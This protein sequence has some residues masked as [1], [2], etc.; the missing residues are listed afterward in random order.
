M[1]NNPLLANNK[2]ETLTTNHKTVHFKDAA[3]LNQLYHP[4][5]YKE[6]AM[7][8][9]RYTILALVI[10]AFLSMIA[11]AQEEGD[12]RSVETGDWSDPSIWETFN[13]TV[14]EAAAAAPTGTETITILGEDSVFVDAVNSVEGYVKVE[15][16]GILTAEEGTLTFADGSTYEHAR[17]GG[18][19]PT[20]TWEEGSTFLITGSVGSAPDN[21]N[22]SY[23]NITFDTDSLV[24]NL[25][26]NL[27]EVTIGGDVRV[28]STGIARWYLTSATAGDTSTVT[29]LGDVIVE[30][31]QF[32]VQGTGNALTVFTVHHY[33]DINVTGGNFSISRGSQGSGSGSTHWYLY[34]GDFTMS[35]ATTQ[36]SNSIGARFVFASADTQAIGFTNVSFAGGRFNFDVS[37]STA[38]EIAQDLSVNG[39]LVNYGMIIPTA[40]LTIANGGIYEHAQNGGTIPAI[41]WAEGS[42]ALF[43]GITTD[44][45]ADRGQGYH[46]LTLNTPDLTSNR[47]LSLDGNTIGGNITV[48]STGTARWQMVGGSSGTVTIMGD[49]I[50]EDGQFA[51]QGTGSATDVE[52]LHH[53]NIIVTGGNFAV[54]RGSQ[55]GVG[56]TR[57][58]LLE[59]DFS[60]SNATTQ[61]SNPAGATFV[62]AKEGIQHLML[63]SVTYAGGGLPIEVAEGSTLDMGSSIIEGNAAFIVNTGGTFVTAHPDGVEGNLQTTGEITLSKEASFMFNGTEAQVTSTLMPDTVCTLIIDNEAGVTLSQETTINCVLRLVSGVFDNTIPFTFGPSGSISYEGGSLLI[64]D[65]PEK[66]SLWGFIGG[67]VAGWQITHGAPGNV[68]LSG[69]T[70]LG[71]GWS[72]IRGEFDPL[73]PGEGE[74]I[75]ISGQINTEGQGLNQ[76]NAIRYGIFRH[77]STGTLEHAGTDSARWSGPE[78]YAYG[79]LLLTMSGTNERANWLDHGTA[80]DFGVIYGGSWISTNSAGSKSLGQRDQ[81]LFRAEAP[82]GLYDFA[83][84][85]HTQEDGNNQL[86]YLLIHED[87][88]YWW[89][90]IAIDTTGV[91]T[92][93]Y[94]GVCF[95]L[96]ADSDDMTAVH[97]IDISVNVGD[98]IMVPDPP[99][100]TPPHDIGRIIN[101]N[102]NFELSVPGVTTDEP[103]W[104]FNYN[105]GGANAVF[106][107][108]DDTAQT[109]DRS[110]MIDFGTWNGASDVWHV[111]AVNEP[112]YPAEGDSIRAT[113][114]LKADEDGR[115]ARIYLGL[116]E[117]GGWQRV[118]NWGMEVV[119][120]LTTEWQ[121]FAFPDYMVIPRDVTHASQSMRF[122]IEF[123][124]QVNDGGMFWIDNAIVRKV[125]QSQVSVEDDPTIPLRF[126]LE[127]NYPNPFNP[128]TQIQFSITE[129]SDVLLEVFDILGRR[130]TTLVNENLNIGHHTVTWDATDQS[131]RSISSGLYIY[132]L[133]AGTKV[134]TKRMMFLK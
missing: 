99:L 63:D 66:V 77:D 13:G 29:I 101:E 56:T 130:V 89:A 62:F 104:S 4:T 18:S 112:F 86:R 133:Q 111:E 19:V 119:C 35:D 93:S 24:S 61:N 49:V 21:R 71:S 6:G 20:A 3:S 116:P 134:E 70:S 26:M 16:N 117:S 123:N 100:E 32:A 74:A 42:T 96:N 43:T 80:G 25:H 88:Q 72:A 65:E 128:T 108:V 124:L 121:M 122:G 90:G 91:P 38:L 12:Y 109:G 67:R 81:R 105:A 47:D 76:W 94:N 102:R 54:S 52:V 97:F 87:G 120:T 41:T 113:V 44:A 131:G 82:E 37:D 58:Y 9:T 11:F 68:T 95:A 28:I 98:P 132:R 57:W 48:V 118:P 8:K 51:T 31:G 27:N 39:D 45:P 5:I 1:R 75:I 14:W 10:I 23:Y 2:R 114:W 129:Q 115:L 60:M 73:T 110:L 59:G 127:Q 36:N 34:E 84:S 83:I 125:G 30:A 7:K 17:D 103:F 69:D 126:A 85:V 106:E 22:Q 33:G 40:E 64:T 107:I 46:H 15:E 55:G 78:N 79:Y 53:G 50:V 92:E